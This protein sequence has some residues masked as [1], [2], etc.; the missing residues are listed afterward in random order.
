VNQEGRRW[1]HQY[2]ES[3]QD[4]FTPQRGAATRCRA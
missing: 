2:P 1:T 3:R 4:D